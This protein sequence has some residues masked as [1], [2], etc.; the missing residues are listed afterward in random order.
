MDYGRFVRL[1]G[2]LWDDFE[3]GLESLRRDRQELDHERVEELAFR[4]RQVLHD[5]AL[6]A[7]RYPGTGA[8]RR[9]RRLS[10]EG[11]RLLAHRPAE[12]RSLARFFRE[13]FPRA[14]RR[15]LP[16]LGLVVALFAVAALAGLL[17][18]MVRPGLG[19]A[20]LGADRVQDLAE[21]R[22]WTESLVTTTPP[23]VST[24]GIATNNASVAITAWAGG[25]LAGLGSLYV[26]LLNGFLLGALVGVTLRYSMARELLEFVTAHGILE[27]TLLL[28][29]AAAGLG[30]ARAVLGGT[31]RPRAEALREA[32]RSSL[33]VLLGCLPWFLLLGVVEVLVSPS[34][35]LGPWP[36]LALGLLLEVLFL[37]TALQPI[38]AKETR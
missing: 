17:L 18:A 6:A 8:T 19:T 25:A 16:P 27:I 4:Y 33:T 36:K 28:V 13:T 23:A 1:R 35:G 21:G 29:A 2:E 9:L 7:T 22:L 11:T 38:A 20:F 15:H 37:A 14:F 3:A 32:G 12:R 26:A 5:H 30:L 24:S 10:V 31:D 34:P